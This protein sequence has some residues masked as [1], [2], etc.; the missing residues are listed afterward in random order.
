[1]RGDI[2]RINSNIVSVIKKVSYHLT[3]IPAI[4]IS[5]RNNVDTAYKANTLQNQIVTIQPKRFHSE[6]RCGA[7][8]MVALFMSDFSS[9][10]IITPKGISQ[11]D[12][13]DEQCTYQHKA[14]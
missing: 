4:V 6:G 5:A 8:L 11:N 7:V 3:F 14:Q 2:R 10:D 12:R 13:D 9:K 1:M